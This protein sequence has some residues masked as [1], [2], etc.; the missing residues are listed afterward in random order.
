MKKV[1]LGKANKQQNG[2]VVANGGGG[3]AAL[4]ILGNSS[5]GSNG[6]IFPGPATAPVTSGGFFKG[7]K[8]SLSNFFQGGGTLGRGK[9]VRFRL[10]I[11]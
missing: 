6:S 10:W 9:K 1:S 8:V 2:G 5:S 11:T 7:P 4:S 3:K